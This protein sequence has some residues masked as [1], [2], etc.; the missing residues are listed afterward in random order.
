MSKFSFLLSLIFLSGCIQ[1]K[2]NDAAKTLVFSIIFYKVRGSDCRNVWLTSRK[3]KLE[4]NGCGGRIKHKDAIHPFSSACPKSL[5]WVLGLPRNVCPDGRA[6]TAFKGRHPDQMPEPAEQTKT[7]V[8]Q[9][10][11][12]QLPFDFTE[13]GDRL[14]LSFKASW[15]K[16][17]LV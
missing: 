15:Q 10:F 9:H 3:R 13:E 5:Q 4:I 1:T 12:W 7:P 8:M 16:E 2:S 6:W 11:L 14:R 17:T